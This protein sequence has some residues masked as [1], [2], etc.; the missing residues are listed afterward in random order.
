MLL[1]FGALSLFL[2]AFVPS[3]VA[4]ACLII[5][6]TLLGLGGPSVNQTLRNAF[7]LRIRISLFLLSV[8]LLGA[9]FAFH[10]HY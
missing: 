4:V 5:G 2:L 3:S 9:A 1:T 8:S 10:R 7:P 6:G